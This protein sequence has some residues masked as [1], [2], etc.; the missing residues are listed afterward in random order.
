MCLSTLCLFT[1]CLSTCVCQSYTYTSLSYVYLPCVSLLYMSIYLCLPILCLFTMCLSTII[2]ARV[3]HMSINPVFIYYL[4]VSANLVSC[5]H[6]SI[7]WYTHM[8]LSILCLSVMHQYTSIHPHIHTRW[9]KGIYIWQNNTEVLQQHQQKLHTRTQIYIH[10]HIRTIWGQWM[11]KICAINEI[12]Q[13]RSSS[14]TSTITSYTHKHTHIYTFTIWKG[15]TSVYNWRN[16]TNV[17]Q[18]QHQQKL[19]QMWLEQQQL[20]QRPQ[21]PQQQVVCASQPLQCHN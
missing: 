17:Q 4:P 16:D 20:K 8:C 13:R 6:V 1:I 14:S 21:Q 11:K 12:K 9:K 5:Y 10:A 7:Y 15:K 3:F 2:R 19:Q 18:K